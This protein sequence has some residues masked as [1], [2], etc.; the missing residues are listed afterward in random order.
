[1]KILSVVPTCFAIGGY[2]S[3]GIESLLN[4]H[5]QLGIYRVIVSVIAT[6]SLI[7]FTIIESKKNRED[8]DKNVKK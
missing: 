1:M 7:I 2:L 6:I 5:I 3:A 8:K 4:N